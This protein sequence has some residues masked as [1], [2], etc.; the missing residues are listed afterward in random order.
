MSKTK[1]E[2]KCDWQNKGWTWGLWKREITL[3]QTQKRYQ[4]LIIV[5]VWVCVFSFCV[6]ALRF[7]QA[8]LLFFIFFISFVF[9]YCGN[10]EN[11]SNIV[12]ITTQF[13]FFFSCRQKWGLCDLFKDSS[14][15]S[16]RGQRQA[17][18]LRPKYKVT[19]R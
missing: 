13:E 14:K 3:G 1:F 18:W 15:L 4:K 19:L 9:I 6:H 7:G 8:L 12:A 5:K 17:Q 11:W 2:V 10:D 16:M